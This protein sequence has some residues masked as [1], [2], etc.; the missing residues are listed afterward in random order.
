MPVR[1]VP[2]VTVLSVV[3][4]LATAAPRLAPGADATCAKAGCHLD[5]L[6]G[7]YVHGVVSAT[8]CS[9]C[10]VAIPTDPAT[11]PK[12]K[13]G[14]AFRTLDNMVCADCHELSGTTREHGAISSAGCSVCHDPH[15]SDNE[16]LLKAPTVRALCDQCH[17][18][19]RGKV[20]HSA[21]EDMGCTHCHSPHVGVEDPL[22]RRPKAALCD[23]C[24]DVSTQLNDPAMKSRHK[25]VLTKSCTG[26]HNP[27]SSEQPRLLKA[28][29]VEVCLECH[30]PGV[31]NVKGASRLS[32]D[33][34]AASPH[35]AFD[36]GF[37]TDCHQ[38]HASRFQRLLRWPQPALCYDCH[39]RKDKTKYVHSAVRLGQCSTCHN[40][41]GGVRDPLLR[42]AKKVDACFVCHDD[43]LTGRAKVH[44]PARSDCEQCHSPHGSDNRRSLVRGGKELCYGCHQRLDDVP[45]KHPVIDQFGCVACH[46]PHGTAND[47]YLIRPVNDLCA[48]CHPLQKDGGHV[49]SVF[50]KKIHK[51]TGGMD[52][53][54]I[55]KK[56]SCASCHNPHGSRR[57]KLLYKGGEGITPCQYCH[58]A[59][60]KVVGL[61]MGAGPVAG[62]PQRN[63]GGSP[64]GGVPSRAAKQ[65]EK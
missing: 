2:K 33:T 14:R 30:A 10:H 57:A 56:F 63:R 18:V 58:A 44:D 46:D 22:L 53:Q 15:T 39:D 38:P 43:D 37:C 1:F 25:P 11:A 12:C 23:E 65:G 21:V 28:D 19:A 54:R 6:R 32:I 8:E 59:G 13:S 36:V 34:R 45:V 4:A 50:E 60:S 42:F 7:K 17:D 16:H 26:C 61:P 27:H 9:V 52:P 47:S 48:E 41:H 31:K 64:A 49:P 24:H 51:V 20:K 5:K 62:P 29:R 55:G 40:P 3:T 35:K